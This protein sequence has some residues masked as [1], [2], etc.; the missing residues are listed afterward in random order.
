MEDLVTEINALEFAAF[1]AEGEPSD[2]RWQQA[3]K[4]AKALDTMSTR[5][6]AAKWL[7]ADGST[8]SHAHVAFTARAW[9]IWGSSTIVD[10]PRFYDAYNSDEVRGKVTVETVEVPTPFSELVEKVRGAALSVQERLDEDDPDVQDFEVRTF[11]DI[12][13]I[14]ADLKAR[15]H[16]LQRNLRVVSMNG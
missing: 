6:L 7:K 14:L 12:I 15:T 3:E 13:E 9:A 10:R 11:D 8:Y 16:R 4:V 1:K 5:D 2:I